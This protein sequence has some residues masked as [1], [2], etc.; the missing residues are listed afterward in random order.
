M[1]NMKKLMKMIVMIGL[2][3]PGWMLPAFSQSDKEL[4]SELIADDRESV[5]ALVMYPADTRLAIL[6]V[7]MNPE[8][9]MR[10]KGIQ[11][12]SQSKFLEIVRPFSQEEQEQ[13]YQIT[14][15]PD[16]VASLVAGDKKS[17]AEIREIALAYPEEIRE[18]AED[19]GIT[20]NS[21]NV[22]LTSKSQVRSPAL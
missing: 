10:M 7:A 17:K 22:S 2:L 8:I 15:Y 20:P 5:D 13:F 4:L 9:L 18:T 3:L 16:L 1:N 19:L 14:R 6:E 11:N 21:L 12:N